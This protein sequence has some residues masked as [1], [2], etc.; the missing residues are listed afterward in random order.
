MRLPAGFEEIQRQEMSRLFGVFTRARLALIPTLL[1]FLAW[2]WWIDPTGWRTVVLALFIPVLA[3]VF[4]FEFRRWQ[5][6][7]LSRHAI[8]RNLA[9]AVIGIVMVSTVSG[10]LES[11]FLPVMLVV[12]VTIGLFA[13]PALATWLMA[14]EIAAVWTFAVLE[15]TR[16][17]LGLRLAALDG[18]RPAVAPRVVTLAAILTLLLVAGRYVG[19]A[20]R[21]AF[22]LMLRRTVRAQAESLRAHADRAEELTALSAEIAHELKNPLASVKGLAGLLAPQLP[23][24]KGAERIGVLRREVD[25]MQAILDEF[26]NFSRPLV[27]LAL[28]THDLVALCREVEALHEGLAQERE[29]GLEIVGEEEQ[30]PARCDPRKV[31]QVLINLVQNAIDAAPA[32]STVTLAPRGLEGGRAEVRVLDRGH[33]LDDTLGGRVFEPGVTTKPAGNGLGLTIARALARQHGGDLTLEPRQG[34][35]TSAQLSLPAAPPAAAPASGAGPGP[36]EAA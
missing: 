12:T 21:R 15:L 29:V 14:T 19:R 11:P 6:R 28:G 13:T 23:D 7:G 5:R 3:T 9:I 22:D 31:K 30:V 16:G 4:I 36:G 35:G 26:L 32:G 25:R 33:G 1:A 34:G 20:I 17:D 8:D 10:G 24:G 27:P 18:G 2:V